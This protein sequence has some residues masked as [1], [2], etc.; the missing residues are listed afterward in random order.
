M[1]NIC[2]QVLCTDLYT[3]LAGALVCKKWNDNIQGTG[4]RC[5]DFAEVQLRAEDKTR[6]HPAFILE[7]FT[8]HAPADLQE[9]RMAPSAVSNPQCAPALQQDFCVLA[10]SFPH[11]AVLELHFQAIEDW[12]PL[13]S[14]PCSLV[15]LNLAHLTGPSCKEY[16]SL[17][18]FNSLRKL[19]VLKLEFRNRSVLADGDPLVYPVLGGQV[20]GRYAYAVVVAGQLELPSLEVL[21]LTAIE[22]KV[23]L[24][25]ECFLGIPTSCELRCNDLLGTLQIA[26]CHRLQRTDII[27][28]SCTGECINETYNGMRDHFYAR[29]DSHSLQL[30]DETTRVLSN[31]NNTGVPA[32]G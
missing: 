14:L 13:R 25:S 7:K 23:A 27:G 9:L 28:N 31:N 16:N 21:H 1:A 22:E 8:Y 4:P 3:F 17:D 20:A 10:G 19:E 6:F 15:S 30:F 32:D 2:Q 12:S 5:M 26:A 11:L 18:I 29:Q 24:L